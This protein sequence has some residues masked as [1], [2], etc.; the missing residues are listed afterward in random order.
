M[1][2]GCRWRSWIAI[3]WLSIHQKIIDGGLH[4]L[5]QKT[6]YSL[7]PVLLS[8]GDL[9]PMVSCWKHGNH[10]WSADFNAKADSPLR[11]LRMFEET[12]KQRQPARGKAR[13]GRRKPASILSLFSNLLTD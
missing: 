7:L 12:V 10:P 9:L 5:R 6:M 2:A 8:A 4:R 13:L 11:S 1:P 3:R